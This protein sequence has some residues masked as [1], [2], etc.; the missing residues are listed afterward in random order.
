MAQ[1]LHVAGQEIQVAEEGVAGRQRWGPGALCCIMRDGGV[2]GE[3]C[4]AP[5]RGS[6]LA[7]ALQQQIKRLQGW[8][9]A[10]LALI[11]GNP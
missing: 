4:L 7:Q 8:R 10:C 6:G 9:Q 5:G 3:G 11:L 2:C 1:E